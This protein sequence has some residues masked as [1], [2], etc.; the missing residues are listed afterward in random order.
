[1]NFCIPCAQEAKYVERWP[2]TTSAWAGWSRFDIP[3][4]RYAGV[5]PLLRW[6][7]SPL[8][9]PTCH[10]ASQQEITYSTKY[11]KADRASTLGTLC[12]PPPQLEYTSHHSCAALST[13]R[14]YGTSLQLPPPLN[15]RSAVRQARQMSVRASS[16]V[17]LMYFSL[18]TPPPPLTERNR[19][20]GTFFKTGRN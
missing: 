10:Q 19:H 20:Y 17:F 14:R 2:N 9:S 11:Q 13:G 4:D 3:V 12:A 7:S 8:G 18:P 5:H 1:M 6:P 15:F 16:L